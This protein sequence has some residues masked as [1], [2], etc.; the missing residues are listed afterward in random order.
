MFI[1]HLSDL[2]LRDENDVVEFAAQLD[3]IVARNPDHLVITGD[4]LD[5]WNPTLLDRAADRLAERG[6]LHRDRLTIIHGNHDLASSGGYPRQRS[7]LW[8]LIARFWDPPPLIATRRREFYRRIGVRATGVAVPAGT[9]KSTRCGLHVA[10]VDTIPAQWIPLKVGRKSLT[11]RHAEGSIPS[12]QL[13]WLSQQ[14]GPDPLIVLMHHYPLPTAPISWNADRHLD[15]PT[16]HLTRRWSQWTRDWR[17]V[18][19]MEIHQKDRARFWSAI[20]HANALA[21]LCGH[22]HRARLEHH[23]DVA[24]GLNGQSGA[25]WAGR[26]IAYYRLEQRRVTVEHQSTSRAA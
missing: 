4:L 22:V 19:P 18:V 1:A 20:D 25:N 15:A 2:H 16:R 3:C 5:W 12:A 10:I 14:R 13:E 6:L 17:I 21:V 26:T 9:M 11:L 8:R 24:V 7:D 23:G